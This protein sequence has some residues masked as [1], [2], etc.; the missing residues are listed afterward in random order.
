MSVRAS[1]RAVA[2]HALVEF[3]RGRVERIGEPIAQARLEP[4]EHAF[5]RSEERRV[6]KECS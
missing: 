1:A 4:R 6:G 3:E 2:L 5:A